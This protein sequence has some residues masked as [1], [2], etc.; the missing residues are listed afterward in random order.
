MTTAKEA[1]TKP[2][3][4]IKL[5]HPYTTAAGAPINQVNVRGINVREMKQAQRRG[6]TDEA[7]TETAMVAVS[8]DLVMEDLDDM[9][10]IDYQAVRAR[11][12]SLNFGGTDG[13]M[14][15]STGSAG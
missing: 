7:E 8:C 13:S 15:E 14:A 6:G 11:F 1:T 9:H 5:K 12:S 10:M 2:N 4:P 3:P